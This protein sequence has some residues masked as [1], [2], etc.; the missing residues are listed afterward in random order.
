MAADL[1]KLYM[2]FDENDNSSPLGVTI[3]M[4]AQQS[5]F[6]ENLFCAPIVGTK[7]W[8]GFAD[9]RMSAALYNHKVVLKAD[10]PNRPEMGLS[11]PV[12]YVF[13]QTRVE[14]EF[15]KCAYVFD[16]ASFMGYNGGCGVGNGNSNCSSNRTAFNNICPSTGKVCTADDDE[17][18]RVMCKPYGPMPV[19]SKG[20]DG[21]C[22]FGMPSLNYPGKARD[23]HLRDMLK[24]RLQHQ[25]GKDDKGPL[26]SHWNE[27]I[28][29]ERLLIPAIGFDPATVISAFIYVKSMAGSRKVAEAMRDKFS[30]YY[31][32]G[33]I[34]VIGVDDTVD[35]TK[36]GGPFV[37]EGEEGLSVTIV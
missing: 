6:H 36:T 14:T 33:K 8:G 32:V 2:G 37:V 30:E 12:G 13:N 4:A 19:P 16:G 15:G 10:Q 20:T 28:L 1:N 31:S 24:A 35:F 5:S 21:Q 22:I 18:K 3:S 26:I 27:V 29:D 11:R 7:C 9:C 34:P 17:I 23:N 25:V